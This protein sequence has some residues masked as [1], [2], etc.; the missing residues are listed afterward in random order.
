MSFSIIKSKHQLC[1]I[2]LDRIL[3]MCIKWCKTHVGYSNLMQKSRY[4]DVEAYSNFKYKFVYKS[5]HQTEI[6]YM[7]NFV[8]KDDLRG[9]I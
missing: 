3:V 7:C 6:D 5:W 9:N 1:L 4:E 8:K 2:K